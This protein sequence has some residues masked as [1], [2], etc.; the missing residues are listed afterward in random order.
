M[1]NRPPVPMS[2]LNE[3]LRLIDDP[4]A[5]Y[6]LLQVL[7]LYS[8]LINQGNDTLGAE[9]QYK[10][11]EACLNEGCSFQT[12]LPDYEWP[13]AL[14]EGLRGRDFVEMV[15]RCNNEVCLSWTVDQWNTFSQ[16]AF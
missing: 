12:S 11:A 4:V 9:I 2:L 14:K 7:R 5:K 8:L 10:E 3:Y 6:C 15:S 1:W 16:V 13:T